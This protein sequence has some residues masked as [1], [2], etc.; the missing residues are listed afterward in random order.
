MEKLPILQ[1]IQDDLTEGITQ[2][3]LELYLRLKRL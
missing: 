2:N 3:G 1:D